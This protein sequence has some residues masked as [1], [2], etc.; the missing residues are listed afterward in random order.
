MIAFITLFYFIFSCTQ[1]K[2]SNTEALVSAE[3]ET[4]EIQTRSGKV[5]LPNYEVVNGRMNFK[6]ESDLIAMYEYLFNKEAK[7]LLAWSELNGYTSMLRWYYYVD[8]IAYSTF[9]PDHDYAPGEDFID[10]SDRILDPQL[11]TLYNSDGTLL[12]GDTIYKVKGKYIYK[13]WEGDSGKANEI[14]NARDHDLLINIP[15]F[16]HTMRLKPEGRPED[17]SY[18]IDVSSTRREFVEFHTAYTSVSFPNGIKFRVWMK[19]QAQT[20]S[21]GIWWPNFDDEIVYGTTESCVEAGVLSGGVVCCYSFMGCCSTYLTNKVN[22][23]VDPPWIGNNCPYRFT[24][25]YKFKKNA[26]H[27]EETYTRVYLK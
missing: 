7:E 20:K 4:Q 8:S 25:T 18:I 19:G 1:G 3:N 11:A 22:I 9:I 23:E 6:C 12:V 15:H 10:K 14:D 16:Q 5:Y 21:L 2:D 27:P 13:I 24:A 26:N 17:R